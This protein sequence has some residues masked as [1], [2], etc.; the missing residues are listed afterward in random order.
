[1]DSAMATVSVIIGLKMGVRRLSEPCFSLGVALMIIVLF[2]DNTFFLLNLYV[3][4][5]GYYIQNFIQQDF[6]TEAFAQLG[7][8]PDGRQAPQWIDAWTIFYWGW[9][10]AWSPFVGIFIA[11][12]SRGRTIRFY[13]NSTLTAPILSSF[14]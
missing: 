7:N 1:M 4:N 12:I 14:L 8:A 2:Y 10:I 13:I 9:W 3:Q 11:R 6:H 5:I